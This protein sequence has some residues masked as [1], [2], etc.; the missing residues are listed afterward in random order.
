M[1]NDTLQYKE[2]DKLYGADKSGRIKEWSATIAELADGSA[3]YTLTYGLQDGKKTVTERPILVGKNIGKTNETTPFEQAC[4]DA[5]SRWNLQIDK[6]YKTDQADLKAESDSELFLPMLAHRYDQRAKYIKFPAFVQ[7]KLDGCRLIARKRDGKVTIWSRK[8]KLITAPKELI[9]EL[10]QN[11]ENE[12]VFDGELYV[13]EWRNENNE[14]DFQRIISAVKKYNQDTPQL[15]YHVYDR[16]ITDK[17]FEERF[18]NNP[19]PSTQR[20]KPVE[21]ILVQNESELMAYFEQWI[22]EDLPYEGLM[23][24]NAADPYVFAHRSNGLQKVK[25]LEDHE[26][27]IIGGQEATGDDAGT[28]IFK[29]LAENGQAFDVRPK[30]SREQRSDWWN[31][32]NQYIGQW[33]TVEFNGRTNSQLP[34]FPRGTRIRPEWDMDKPT[35]KVRSDQEQE[36]PTATH[37]NKKSSKLSG[38][39]NLSDLLK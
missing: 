3:V 13:N 16:P 4:F 6:G 30:G 14:T 35:T 25:P 38:G 32:L 8:G 12:E 2:L 9:A 39:I 24:R 7:K 17:S 28:V 5:Q 19:P 20:I 21:T 18:I 36:E 10:E 1:G 23:V 22:T 11:M 27:Q 15:E 26:F 34:R 33:L 29:C 31:N 37:K